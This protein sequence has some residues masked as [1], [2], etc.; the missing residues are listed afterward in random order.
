MFMNCSRKFAK[1]NMT[2]KGGILRNHRCER[3]NMACKIFKAVNLTL[4]GHH[5]YV[6]IVSQAI[7]IN[8]ENKICMPTKNTQVVIDD[9]E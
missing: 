1:T 2:A 9:K 4:H 8:T 5:T 3:T 7:S 6:C